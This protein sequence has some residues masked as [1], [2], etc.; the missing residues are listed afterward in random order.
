MRRFKLFLI[1]LGITAAMSACQKSEFKEATHNR[2]ENYSAIFDMMSKT[3]GQL[4][5]NIEDKIWNKDNADICFETVQEDYEKIIKASGDKNKS[6]SVYIVENTISG[7]IHVVDNT[8]YCTIEDIENLAYRPFLT[9][10]VFGFSQ[11]WKREGLSACIF[12][13]A[14]EKSDEEIKAYCE[15]EANQ[16]ILSLIPPYFSDDFADSGQAELAKSAALS[17]TKYTLE[18]LGMEEYLKED[19]YSNLL[20]PW[21][22]DIGLTG[23][24]AHEYHFSDRI[25]EDYSDSEYP[26]TLTVDNMYFYLEPRQWAEN[27]DKLFNFFRKNLNAIVEMKN[28]MIDLGIVTY[29]DA[30]SDQKIYF[31]VSSKSIN[32]T[33]FNTKEINLT[34]ESALCHEVTHIIIPSNDKTSYL[35]EGISQYFSLPMEE[36]YF[37]NSEEIQRKFKQL[38]INLNNI[39]ITNLS[40]SD[41]QNLQCIEEIQKYYNSIKPLPNNVS[42]FDLQLFYEAS[43]MVTLKCSDL[44]PSG[45]AFLPIGE[46]RKKLNSFSED[47][48]EFEGNGLNYPEAF[49][50]VRYLIQTYD[51]L[52]VADVTSGKKSFEEG[53][54]K[55]YDTVFAEF[56]KVVKNDLV[57]L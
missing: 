34:E 14:Q 16:G 9:Q 54:G 37:T 49:V 55:D 30:F 46:S 27:A 32:T 29:V 26:M 21:L 33:N 38:T 39:N 19:N 7:K 17:L 31:Y 23:I 5:V 48:I 12:E 11:S 35:A 2:S 57:K 13:D 45:F 41:Y 18:N 56:M 4:T 53:F 1:T 40:D 51:A 42:E 15:D 50:F 22:E 36:K 6:I 43:A 3:E 52:T 8:L 25:K 24:N 47:S 20:Q 10:T 44:N 28:K